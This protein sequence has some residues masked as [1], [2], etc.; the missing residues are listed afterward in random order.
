MRAV[1]GLDL[2]VKK[3]EVVSIMGRSG[4][5]KSTLMRQLG[6]LDRPTS[7]EVYLED[8]EVTKISDR[9]RSRMRLRLLGYVFQE[10]ALLPELT[11]LENV[12][13]PGMMLG[14]HSRRDY[15][16]RAQ[17]LLEKVG[18]GHRINH[19]PRELSGGEQ[20]R[21]E[22]ARALI[23]EPKY[24]F[25]DEPAASLDTVSAEVVMKTLVSLNKELGVTVIFV[26]HEPTDKKYAHRHIYLR[27]GKLVKPYL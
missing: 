25:A 4:S 1:S 19:L 8:K 13:L 6:L 24:I 9:S 21:V 2:E 26:S 3:G 10:Y 7:G 15:K 22:I 17:K 12:F 27:D 16:E 5:G 14:N 18:L 20:Q 11:A 23:N